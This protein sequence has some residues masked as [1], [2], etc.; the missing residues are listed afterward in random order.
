MPNASFASTLKKV[1][2]GLRLL[3]L[4]PGAKAI[5]D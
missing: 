4:D 2:G 3:Q 5:H 1:E